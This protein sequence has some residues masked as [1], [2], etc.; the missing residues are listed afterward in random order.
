MEGFEV[1]YGIHPV[2][3]ALQSLQQIDTILIKKSDHANPRIMKL[4][5]LAQ[6]RSIKVKH[7]TGDILQK[8]SADGVHQGI[9]ALMKRS[10][11]I[12]GGIDHSGDL[13]LI[14]DHITDVGNMG[15]ILRSA[16][17][18]RSDGIVIPSRRSVDIN[19]GVKKTSAGAA[20][21]VK[22]HRVVNLSNE[23]EHFKKK[24]YWITGA[25]AE[26]DQELYNFQ[27]PRKSVIVLGNEEKGISRMVREK[28]DYHVRI[29]RF[30]HI[31]SLNV[32]VAAGLFLFQYRQ[33]YK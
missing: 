16:D 27:F 20:Q 1:V 17:F 26:G 14:L 15:A 9:C 7:V 10:K 8:Y 2:E 30:G 19:E 13:Y 5:Y 23:I 3:E 18:F 33:L 31:K 28:L 12:S 4:I 25:D 32:S 24:G 29:S 21:Y 6:A 11:G 22:V